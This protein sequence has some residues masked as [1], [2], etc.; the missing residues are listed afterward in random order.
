MLI[1]YIII[2]RCV[3]VGD[4]ADAGVCSF[5]PYFYLNSSL[6][7]HICIYAWLYILTA[8]VT[9][10]QYRPALCIAC[11]YVWPNCCPDQ[12]LKL[13]ID[14]VGLTPSESSRLL[15]P[16]NI[17]LW[18]LTMTVVS[19]VVFAKYTISRLKPGFHSNASSQSWLPLLRPSIPIAWR[20]RLLREIFTQQMQAPANRNARSKQ[21]QVA[22]MIGTCQRKHLRFL[23]FSFTPHAT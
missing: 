15:I 16:S 1:L 11:M 22:T 14:A 17:I 3:V 19:R 13:L 23:R 7:I 9:A 10:R 4:S 20:L 8:C 6:A 5:S 21:W 12:T 2:R 18:E